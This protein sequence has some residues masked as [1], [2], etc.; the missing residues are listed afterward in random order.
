[1]SNNTEDQTDCR[2][3]SDLHRIVATPSVEGFYGCVHEK[4]DMSDR[5]R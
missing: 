3:H 4:A 5:G 1:M 2:D